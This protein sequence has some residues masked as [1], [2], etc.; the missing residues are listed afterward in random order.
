MNKKYWQSFGELTQSDNHQQASQN[1]F[2]EELLPL[3]DLDGKGILDAATPRRDFLKYLGFS[4]AA[5][6]IGFSTAAAAI[7][8]SC[9]TPVKK[10]VP[11]LNRPDDVT[12]GIANYY[13]STYINAGDAISVVVKQRDGRPIKIEGNELSSVT[14]GGTSAQAQASVLDL[15]DPTRLRHPLQKS[16]SEFK[17][18]SSFDAFDKMVADAVA[19]QG[20]KSIVLLTATIHSPSTLQVISEFH[21]PSTLQV[22]S[23]FLAKYPGSRHVQYDAV[24]YSGMLQANELS[25]GKRVIPSYQFNKAKTIVSLGADF[26]GTWLSPTEFSMQYA[27][28]YRI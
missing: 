8:A 14:K 13:A 24:S 15:Y 5:A 27:E 20:A 11:Y 25:Y 3:A 16:G 22:I 7:A 2:Q 4:T 10:S 18:V 6:A 19:A 9:Q 21:S 12:P 26:L 1:E 23:E 17:E 28:P